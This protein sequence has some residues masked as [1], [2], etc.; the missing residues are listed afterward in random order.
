MPLQFILGRA[1]S[2][3]SHLVR[4]R[5]LDLLRDD[6]LGPPVFLVVPRQSTFEHEKRFAVSSDLP[7]FLRL[8]V[9]GFD[10][11]LAEIARMR[12]DA[13]EPEV[14]PAGRELLLGHLLRTKADSLTFFRAAARHVGTVREIERT[15]SEFDRAGVSPLEAL[16]A[17][18]ASDEPD[19][20]LRSKL[21][22]LALLGDAYSKLLAGR[23][24]AAE[25]ARRS[26]EAIGKTPRLNECSLFV[27]ELDAIGGVDRRVLIELAS[28]CASTTVALR[29]DP[30]SPVVAKPSLLPDPTSLFHGSAELYRQLHAAAAEAKVKRLR[31]VVLQGGAR[32]DSPALS[33]IERDWTN[34]RASRAVG[35][36]A[37]AVTFVE[38]TD[39]RQQAE[40]AASAVKDWTLGGGRLRDCAVLC[41]S[42]DPHRV[43]LET[44]F[45]EQGLTYFID[46]RRPAHHHPTVR[47]L[48]ALL[49][50][51]QQGWPQDAA[52]QLC[53]TGLAGI[54]G[55][56]AD[57]LENFVLDHR[58]RGTRAW[59]QETPW[60]HGHAAREEGDDT[61]SIAS[62]SAKAADALRRP[63]AE[64]IS[65]LGSVLRGVDRP[66]GETVTAIWEALDRFHIRD[67]VS[68]LVTAAEDAGDVAAAAEHRQAWAAVCDLLDATT[69][70]LGNEHMSGRDFVASIDLALDRLE[71]AVTPPTVDA[72]TIG[73]VERTVLPRCECCV[74]I[75]L[76]DGEFPLAATYD[77]VLGDDERHT[78]NRRQIEIDAGGTTRQRRER[79]LAY[80]ATTRASRSLTLVRSKAD[81]KGRETAPSP[82]W[83]RLRTL[84]GIDV[85]S[86]FNHVHSAASAA[87]ASLRWARN[88]A[89]ESDPV[90]FVY[91]RLQSRQLLLA[92]RVWSS[93]E[94]EN[95]PTLSPE[96]AAAALGDSL[97]TSVS[98]LE[99]FAL[100]PFKHFSAH[101]LKLRSRGEPELTPLDLGVIY[102]DVL[103]R[104][105]RSVILRELAMHDLEEVER[106]LPTLAA[107]IGERLRGGLINEDARGRFLLDR[108]SRSLAQVVRGQ[109]RALSIGAFEPR[110]TEVSFGGEGGTLPPLEL[111]VSGGRVVR[112]HGRIDRIDLSR[113]GGQ[114]VIIDYKTTSREVML[115]QKEIYQRRALQL[116][117]YMLAL[118]ANG[119]A[120]TEPAP[121]PVAALYVKLLRGV[122]KIDG[123]PEG[124]PGPDDVGFDLRV[125]PR[126]VIDYD[127]A[128]LLDAEFA[129]DDGDAERHR[130]HQSAAFV[131]KTTKNGDPYKSGS[132]LIEAELLDDL[133]LF[134]RRQVRELAAGILDGVIDV[135]PLRDA[136]WTPC[137][138]CS[139]SGVCRFEPSQGYAWRE[140]DD[141]LTEAFAREAAA[142]REEVAR[143]A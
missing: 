13:P 12:G 64:K 127:H 59:T 36:D 46:H 135:K 85:L 73:D 40:A 56:E 107:E 86:D 74:V 92:R 19:G 94:Y 126:G 123:D 97:D 14:T 57:L 87:R 24:D 113:D 47:F 90:A 54:E 67:Q 118:Q 43:L 3:K 35:V 27:D 18:D 41:R 2:G 111:P 49:R 91:D 142:E 106:R 116:L 28:R 70:L 38:A 55:R 78:L 120:L 140:A 141:P 109:E 10:G 30:E 101:T 102:H 89:A 99:S 21:R 128:P 103:E 37:S 7:G 80:L 122:E 131:A 124:K 93:L 83:L 6:P 82:V 65:P 23:T 9:V 105:I 81:Q 17:L 79:F 108:V 143:D 25:R 61:D 4:S 32:F 66:A 69:D 76:N 48:R 58:I 134:V 71:F 136:T 20:P 44:A 132:D 51:A 121:Q 15:L 77:T 133:L 137:S 119:A 98:R 100:C 95:T 125:P 114:A 68:T 29:L 139:F 52:L 11:L 129:N 5:I 33:L 130:G 72:V 110:F 104:L 75:G 53:K 115:K 16:E 62:E 45:A 31:P 96:V 138:T 26:V 22:D 112:I 84:L 60:R 1:G 39:P 8:R 88:G 50:V 63:L 34:P 42:L 117:V